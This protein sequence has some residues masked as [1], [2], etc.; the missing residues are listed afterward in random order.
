MIMVLL[1]WLYIAMTS[2]AT[3]IAVLSFFSWIFDRK[4]KEKPF[5]AIL[6]GLVFNTVYAQ[7]WSLF[8][9]VGV[10]ANAVLVLISII[11]VIV[12]K[13]SVSASIKG[14]IERIKSTRMLAY[15]YPVLIVL[16]AY[17]TSRGYIHYDTS[18]YHA[19]S[20]RWIEEYGVVKGLAC[21][22]LRFGYNSSAF[23]L[24]ALYSLADIFGQSL[25][26]TAGF[27]CLLGAFQVS[28]V[29]E[30]FKEKRVR[31]SDF[32][33]IGLL[34]YLGL[35]FKEMVSPASDYYAQI[36]IFSAVITWLDSL[37][38]DKNS[39]SENISGVQSIYPYAMISI[40]LVFAA[41]VKFSI[42]LLVL[43]AIKPAVMLIRNRYFKQMI[44]SLLAGILTL[45]PFFIRNVL[46]SGWLI[47][48]STFIDLFDVDWKI[49]KGVAQYDAMEIGVYGKGIND[50]T[51]LDMPMRQ[52]LPAWFKQMSIVEKGWVSL[53]AICLVAG[54][55]YFIYK[56]I[57]KQA[58]TDILL[59]FIVLT[60]SGLFWFF[61]APLVRYG[62]GYL[63]CIPLFVDGCLCME[64]VKRSGDKRSLYIAFLIVF[65][66]VGLYRIKTVGYDIISS[67]KQPYYLAQVDYENWPAKEYELMP[68][69][70]IYVPEQ[71]ALIGY[72]KFPAS[73]MTI[74]IEMRGDDIKDGFRYKDYEA[75][76]ERSGFD[77][78]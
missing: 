47:Y 12:F 36:L 8:G 58:D 56:L 75:W 69:K 28:D 31:H 70:I 37:E 21:L 19:Q 25:H 68:G 44:F 1:N 78:E 55:I 4:T 62:Y 33:R 39:T 65:G 16:F 72:D 14:L 38:R 2:F 26:T 63:T 49:P 71:D 54:V 45:L 41:T 22:Q 17:G 11:S 29:Y 40:L 5:F 46:I 57:K 18:L 76:L 9:G 20:I 35:I 15:I 3:G 52:W 67:L 10:A 7:T 50:V 60:I 61:S 73:L 24:T 34:F 30:V 53:T 77:A 42:A 13:D 32:I 43:L 48:P 74:D 59:V 23:A 51:K 64:L 6:A 66:V 27:F